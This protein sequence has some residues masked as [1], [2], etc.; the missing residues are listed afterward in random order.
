VIA[1][2]RQ[3]LDPFA[4]ALHLEPRP[5]PGPRVLVG[6]A[7]AVE[8]VA[9]VTT[10]GTGPATDL[11]TSLLRHYQIDHVIGIGIVGGI[12]PSVAIGDLVVPETVVDD[13][14]GA[15]F[16]PVAIDGHVPRGTLLTSDALVSD[17]Q[18]IPELI[19]QGVV[20]VDMETAAIGAVCERQ[21]VPWS[22]LRAVSDRASDVAIDEAVVGLARPDGSANPRAIARFLLTRPRQVPHLATLA[23]GM[24]AATHASAAAAVRACRNYGGGR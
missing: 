8:V 20:A 5:G 6:T 22:V 15:R 1:A 2:M 21:G 10:M 12:D 4:A 17:K 9:A 3:E 18:S 16:H 23:R 19:E 11:T 7:G 13:V 14:S 24:R